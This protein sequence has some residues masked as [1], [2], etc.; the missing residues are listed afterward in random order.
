MIHRL[1]IFFGLLILG[2]ITAIVCTPIGIV[3]IFNGR[4]SMF[5]FIEAAINKMKNE[6]S[7]NN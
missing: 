4:D 7:S 6:T 5:D 1:K 3:W 2:I